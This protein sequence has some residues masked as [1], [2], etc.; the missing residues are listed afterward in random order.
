MERRRFTSPALLLV[1][2]GCASAHAI[3]AFNG[4]PKLAP[5]GSV[6]F[7]RKFHQSGVD[8]ENRHHVYLNA[9]DESLGCPPREERAALARAWAAQLRAPDIVMRWL[10]VI[11]AKLRSDAA[12]DKAFVIG[13]A[14]AAAKLYVYEA[15]PDLPVALGGGRPQLVG[16][17]LRGMDVCIARNCTV[18]IVSIEW[19]RV[20]E[21][22]VSPIGVVSSNDAVARGDAGRPVALRYYSYQDGL[23]TGPIEDLDWPPAL[24]LR[25]REAIAHSPSLEARVHH[26][27]WRSPTYDPRASAR[28]GH[29]SD[30]RHGLLPARRRGRRLRARSH[31]ARPLDVERHGAARSLRRVVRAGHGHDARAG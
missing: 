18:E 29:V 17:H 11:D 25:A 22:G 10:D 26:L 5:W 14:D 16:D 3:D 24:K 7:S 15:L 9:C 21:I 6:G 20:E 2:A 13:V 30:D 31:A 8:D 4:P 28:A 12:W 27:M 1:L 19:R 23:P